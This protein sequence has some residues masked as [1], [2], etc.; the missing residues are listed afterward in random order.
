[1][2][3]SE[4]DL[5]PRYA[6]LKQHKGE[7][8][9]LKNEIQGM[10][11]SVPKGD[12]KKKKEVEEKTKSMQIEME[13]K[14]RK[15]LEELDSD[16]S[17]TYQCEAQPES[18]LSEES[19]SAG[20][21]KLNVNDNGDEQGKKMS[22]AEK[23]RLKKEA[24][25]KERREQIRKETEGLVSER[26]VEIEQ[27][28]KQLSP[29]KLQIKQIKPDGHCLYSALADQLQ[30]ERHD[31]FTLR[32]ITAQHIRNHSSDFIPFLMNEQGDMLTDSE[33]VKYCDDVEN[34]NCWGGEV[35]L[36]AISGELGVKIE[37]YQAGAKAPH[38]IGEDKHKGP[39]RVSYH[40]H[41][42]GLGSHYNSVVL[43]KG[44]D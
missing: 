26:E 5:S 24:E 25:A 43:V 28:K 11:K 21:Y 32:K 39:L 19:V 14:H 44:D 36:Q 40:R 16:Q 6:L 8:K 41:E 42:Y 18:T 17:A 7:L 35:E 29:L 20:L 33:F 27:L 13:Q 12:K 15:E 30:S 10:K 37:V 38:V 22:R 34:T 31:I 9:K 4:E 1:M 3:D 23:R 2:S